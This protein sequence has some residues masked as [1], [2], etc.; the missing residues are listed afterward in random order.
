MINSDVNASPNSLPEAS[1]G[2]CLPADQNLKD[3]AITALM[4]APAHALMDNVVNAAREAEN[5][6]LR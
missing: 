2:T 4:S 6:V 3:L 5:G 1:C